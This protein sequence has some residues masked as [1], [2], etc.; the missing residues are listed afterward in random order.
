MS[1][2]T[3]RRVLALASWLLILG[4]GAEKPAAE[5]ASYTVEGEIQRLPEEGRELREVWIRH[6][7]IPDFV[8]LHGEV[9]GMEPMSMPFPAAEDLSLE[10]LEVGDRVE[11]EFEVDWQG[12]PPLRL[13]R[14]E[15][16]SNPAPEEPPPDQ[17][18]S[19][20]N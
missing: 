3:L 9:V 13:T 4:C 16:L 8:D 12:D 15:K 20:S 17:D 11:F 14:I 10:G 2:R 19:S 18:I 6:E 5:A 1:F 7:E